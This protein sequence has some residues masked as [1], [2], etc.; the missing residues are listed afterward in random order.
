MTGASRGIG[1]AIACA[2]AADGWPVGVNYRAD[3]EGA[4]R[5]VGAIEAAG[6]LAVALQGD[7][8]SAG[9]VARLFETLEERHVRVLV[10]VNC[11]GVRSDRLF[12]TMTDDDWHR[13]VDTN[14]NG[15]YR[16]IRRALPAMTRARFGRVVS[17]G[18][19]IG[20]RPLPG[21]A[22]YSVSK[23]ALEALTRTVAIEVAR[24][25]VTINVVAPGL[26]ET[27]LTSDVATLAD[28][29]SRTI[30][31]S[32]R[33]GT[34]EDVAACVRFLA[35]PD[36]G[37]VTGTTV[38]VDGG[39]SASLFPLTRTARPEPRQPGIEEPQTQEATA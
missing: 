16:T 17:V 30:I 38:V 20:S 11:A 13:V 14:L 19:I 8:T 12:L 37:Y 24:R 1:A 34:T 25:G 9:D 36:A 28:E 4:A 3:A 27:E 5:V 32:R 6:G 33:A 26:V 2:I 18:S 10:L 29:A 22:N 39:L 7:V 23:A 15:A 35:S 21:L 31:P